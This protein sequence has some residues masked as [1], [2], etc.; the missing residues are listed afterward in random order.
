MRILGAVVIVGALSACNKDSGTP[1]KYEICH[2]D[3]T[4]C[5]VDARFKF[6]ESCENYRKIS[7]MLCDSTKPGE[8]TCRASASPSTATARCTR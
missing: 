7:E 6:F 1:V 8:V 2:A 4:G 5:F 3:G